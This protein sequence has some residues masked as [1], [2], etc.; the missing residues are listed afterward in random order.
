MRRLL[1][2]LCTLLLL[3]AAGPGAPAAEPSAS[4]AL[5]AALDEHWQHRLET[6]ALLRMRR[7]LPVHELPDLSFAAAQR[8]AGDA[9]LGSG[10]LPLAVLEQHV[11]WWIEEEKATRPAT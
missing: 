8:E 5:A 2:S 6:E 1:P 10:S 7:G 3:A 4:R 11:D 9:V